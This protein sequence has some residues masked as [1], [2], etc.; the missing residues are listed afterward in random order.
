MTEFGRARSVGNAED[1]REL[2]RGGPGLDGERPQLSDYGSADRH[3]AAHVHGLVPRSEQSPNARRLVHTEEVTVRRRPG[4]TAGL[5]AFPKLRMRGRFP[6]SAPTNR[7]SVHDDVEQEQ[8]GA[9]RANEPEQQKQGTTGERICGTRKRATGLFVATRTQPPDSPARPARRS[10]VTTTTRRARGEESAAR[11]ARQWRRRAQFAARPVRSVPV[12]VQGRTAGNPFKCPNHRVKTPNRI[13]RAS[14]DTPMVK[15]RATREPGS[16][17]P[18]RRAGAR[19][20][21][22]CTRQAT[23]RPRRAPAAD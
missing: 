12:A 6:S 1:G 8:D 5:D 7:G 17:K 23:G 16:G 10:L 4:A 14:S 15:G 21:P 13:S 22:T 19:R 11:P 9:S 18:C 20:R 3:R 2:G